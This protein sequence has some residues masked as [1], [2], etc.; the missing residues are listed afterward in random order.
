LL[1]A[2][3]TFTNKTID[4]EATGNVCSLP[5]KFFIPFAGNKAGAASS[6]C[7]LPTSNAPAETAE[8]SSPMMTAS[9]GYDATTD[10]T[11]MFSHWL[12][13]DFDATRGIDVVIIWHAAATTGAATFRIENACV[14]PTTSM[15]APTFNSIQ[16][17]TSTTVNGT[18]NGPNTSAINSL[19]LSGGASAE[20]L[21]SRMIYFRV[22][23]DA[24]ST[25]GVDNMAGDALVDGIEVTL[26]RSM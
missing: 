11:C 1:A 10:E 4:C 5:V 24:D 17:S 26:R 2:T 16:Y 7:N 23:R 8:G 12:P 21:A 18:T 3:Q 9:L 15:I 19:T 14:G 20:C 25:G 6:I 13:S 22:G